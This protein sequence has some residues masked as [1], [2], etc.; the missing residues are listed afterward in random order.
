M[1]Q[2]REPNE[3]RIE[4]L[5]EQYKLLEE[6]RKTFGQE[7]MQTLGFF[8]ALLAVVVGLLGEDN[9]ILLAAVLR[10]AGG[11]F[12]VTAVLA[13]RLRTRQDD[14]QRSLAEIENLLREEVG[15]SIGRLP[16]AARLGARLMIVVTLVAVGLTL[17]LVPWSQLLK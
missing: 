13:Q 8:I 1:K 7:L 15:G 17:L 11:I 2:G 10:T 12:I 14:C 16:G 6:R 5:L 4:V 3:C 9:P